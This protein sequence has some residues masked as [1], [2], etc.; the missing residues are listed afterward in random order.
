MTFWA[1][2]SGEKGQS[3]AEYALLFSLVTLAL[4][5]TCAALGVTVG[6]L[7]AAVSDVMP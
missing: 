6:H 4:I 1:F 5:G 3:V 7:Y 2:L